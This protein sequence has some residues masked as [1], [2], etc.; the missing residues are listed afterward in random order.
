MAGLPEATGR[1]MQGCG[2]GEGEGK[3]GGGSVCGVGEE[4]HNQGLA[5]HWWTET[6]GEAGQFLIICIEAGCCAPLWGGGRSTGNFAPSLSSM[7]IY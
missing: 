4:E 2:R 7:Y 6:N 5:G 1:K 3:G